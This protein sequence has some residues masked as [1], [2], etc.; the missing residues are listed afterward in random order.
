M[1]GEY[2]CSLSSL[3]LASSSSF[4][5]ISATIAPAQQA[6]GPEADGE[7]LGTAALVHTCKETDPVSF[8]R[9]SLF[10]S[11]RQVPLNVALPRS[12]RFWHIGTIPEVLD[13]FCY[14]TSFLLEAAGGH[15]SPALAPP[16]PAFRFEQGSQGLGFYVAGPGAACSICSRVSLRVTMGPRSVLE[17]STAENGVTVGADSF[18]SSVTLARDTCIPPGTFLQTLALRPCRVAAQGTG[19]AEGDATR[20]PA[21][22]EPVY[23]TH[24]MGTNDDVKKTGD[25]R[26]VSW[27]GLTLEQACA[28]LSIPLADLWP[29]NAPTGTL[30]NA[31]L[32][33]VCADREQSVK[34]ALAQLRALRG[35]PADGAK[36]SSIDVGVGREGG[37]AGEGDGAR[38][39]VGGGGRDGVEQQHDGVEQ[40]QQPEPKKRKVC[41]SLSR[42]C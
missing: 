1:G 11:L 13:H 33:P 14:R 32:F 17:F 35:G 36:E 39:E 22:S 40:Q 19:S 6:L 37:G 23:V 26:E 5:H 34:V 28:N 8:Y 29:D 30:W 12:S 41:D 2:F 25:A 18:I 31:R 24:V 16:A 20:A 4:S 9:R 15:H 10:E 27:L 38:P 7:H 21:D 42:V 3:L